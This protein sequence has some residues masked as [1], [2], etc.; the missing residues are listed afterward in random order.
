M[1]SF[2]FKM[3][4]VFL[5]LAT[6]GGIG[7]VSAN[8]QFDP[9][10][11]RP[12]QREAYRRKLAQVRLEE[13]LRSEGKKI[14][15]AKAELVSKHFDFGMLDPHTTASHTFE[16]HNTGNAD[17]FV[18]AGETSCKCTVGKVGAEIVPPGHFTSVTLEW[19][20]GYQ[21]DEYEQ[22]A[23]VHTND[24]L[25][26][27]IT[28]TV[29][30]QVRAEMV[31]L[32]S[33]MEMP[34][35]DL[36]ETANGS[37][38]LYSQLWSDFVIE[39]VECDLPG[40]QWVAEP[41]DVKELP[42]G[43]LDAISAWKLKLSALPTQYGKIA[44]N[45]K[46]TITPIDGSKTLVR[47]IS[48]TGAVR[49]PISFNGPDLDATRGLDLGIMVR[50]TEHRKSISVR[51]RGD[52]DRKLAVLDVMPK[53]MK[54]EIV[55]TS[56]PGVYRLTLIA[57]ADASTVMFNRTDSHGYVQ[58]GDPSNKKLMNWMPI[59]GAIINPPSNR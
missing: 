6:I 1:K 19:N 52:T 10:G 58:V 57:P 50:G 27:A 16:I 2:G 32:N 42:S 9:E 22:S 38:L 41:V 51:F 21:V 36:G 49:T 37:T 47:E 43:D 30:G 11:V 59:T 12:E 48:L 3:S 28:L 17:L 24:P 15:H 54:A 46:I 5:I 26:P 45:A 13:A 39:S 34:H 23:I 14:P 56:Q 20:T 31:L 33:S 7:I 35:V 53:Q 4:L 8:L 18:K 44:G 25:Q 40:F 55:E 29:K